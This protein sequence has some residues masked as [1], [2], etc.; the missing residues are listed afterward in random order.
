VEILLEAEGFE[1]NAVE[2]E[3]IQETGNVIAIDHDGGYGAEDQ[4]AINH[5]SSTSRDIMGGSRN[6]VRACSRKVIVGN[7]RGVS[8]KWEILS[9]FF[10]VTTK[11]TPARRE[12]ALPGHR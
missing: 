5:D 3:K 10:E 8:G 9:D 7:G 6:D 2:L 12:P 1:L 4:R 11:V